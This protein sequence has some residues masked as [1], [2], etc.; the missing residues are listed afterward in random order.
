MVWQSRDLSVEDR[1]EEA[2]VIIA[3]GLM[4]MA[5]DIKDIDEDNISRDSDNIRYN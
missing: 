4:R 1:L 5:A 3:L 2:S